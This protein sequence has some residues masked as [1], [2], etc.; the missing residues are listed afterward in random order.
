LAEAICVSSL[1]GFQYIKYAYQD[2]PEIPIGDDFSILS[3]FLR[4]YKLEQR[5]LPML[6][7]AGKYYTKTADLI[8]NN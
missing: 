4:L 7:M 1:I 3:D 2:L 5:Q 6:E 8:R